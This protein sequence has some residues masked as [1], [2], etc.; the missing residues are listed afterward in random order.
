M[1]DVKKSLGSEVLELSVF[2][3][4]VAELEQIC[5]QHVLRFKDVLELLDL[6]FVSLVDFVIFQ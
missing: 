4:Q 2:L 5:G 1:S 6:L 3:K